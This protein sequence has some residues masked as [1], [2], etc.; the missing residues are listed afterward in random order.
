LALIFVQPGIEVNAVVD[1]ATTEVNGGHAERLEQRYTHA[2]VVSGFLP[3]QTPR[4]RAG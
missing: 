1:P 2:E 3:G 4:E